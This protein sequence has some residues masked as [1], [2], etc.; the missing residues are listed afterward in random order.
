MIENNIAK[1][2]MEP[3]PEMIEI[4]WENLLDRN[5]V[6]LVDDDAI[7]SLLAAILAA[8]SGRAA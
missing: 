5:E 8:A 3:S 2:L 7:K 6:A 4:V 1:A